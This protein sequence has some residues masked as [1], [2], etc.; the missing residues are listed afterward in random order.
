MEAMISNDEEKAWMTSLLEFRNKFG[1][2]ELDRDRRSFRKMVGYEWKPGLNAPFDPVAS[3]I[4]EEE[5]MCVICADGRDIENTM[6]ILKGEKFE[7]TI[8]SD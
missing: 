1:N 7:G 2:E 4:A 3:G 8:I 5:G 6:K